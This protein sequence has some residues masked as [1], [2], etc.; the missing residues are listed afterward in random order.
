MN[1]RPGIDTP[2]PKNFILVKLNLPFNDRRKVIRVLKDLEQVQLGAVDPDRQH[3]GQSVVDG[4]ALNLLVGFGLRFFLGPHKDR[5]PE[6]VIQNFPPGGVFNP[7]EPTRFGIKDRKVP[8]YLR[9]MNA[10]GDLEW[11]AN[12]LAKGKSKQPSQKQIDQAYTQW[13]SETESDLM[14]YIESNNRFLNMDLWHRIESAVV[15]P[16]KLELARPI[17]E[18]YGREDGRDLIGWHDPI[19][20]MDEFIESNPKYYRSKIYLPY[21]APMY[22][23]EPIWNRDEPRYNSGT[24]L[25]H[26]KYIQDLD[27]WNSDE[28]TFTD[29]YGRV[30]Q[31]E[32]A[33]RRVIGRDRETGQVISAADGSLLDKEP[34]STE[35]YMAPV[36]SHI[37]QARGGS[38]VPFESPFPPLKKGETNAFTVQDQRIRRRGGNWR[39]TDPETSKV[40]YGLHFICFQNNIQQNGFE[41]INNIWLLNPMFRLNRDYLLDPERGIGEPI[42]GCYYFVPPPHSVYAGEVFFE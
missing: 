40:N 2:P 5:Q 28:F 4:W 9:T 29:N 26:R 34:D 20:N 33:R 10:T 31:G 41:F 7:R 12:R 17:N 21:P 8:M 13:L 36:D 39:E 1:L 35:A 18:S 15:E 6:E 19:S 23:G 37:L 32:E 14:L 42:D 38:G 22:P 11:V 16:H 30:F 27:K 3:D 24:Y 25:V